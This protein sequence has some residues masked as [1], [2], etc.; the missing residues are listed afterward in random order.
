[1]RKKTKHIR[2]RILELLTLAGSP[3]NVSAALQKEFQLSVPQITRYLKGL[4]K[5]ALISSS[6]YGK[7]KKYELINKDSRTFLHSLKISHADLAKK[8]EDK[9]YDQDIAPHLSECNEAA[10][11]CIRHAST[12]LINNVID[13]SKA[14]SMSLKV[15]RQENL[16][17]IELTDDGIGVFSS[18]KKFF[19]LDNFYEAISELNKGKRTTDAKHHAGEGIYFSQRMVHQFSIEANGLKYQYYSEKKDWTINESIVKKGT[20]VTFAVDQRAKLFPQQ[21]FEEYTDKNFKFVKSDSFLV[22]PYFISVGESVVS[23]SEA[24]KLLAGAEKFKVVVLDFQGTQMIG[25]GFAD[26]AF[27]VFVNLHPNIE[28]TYKN[29][30]DSVE[31]MIGHVLKS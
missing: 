16:L 25:Q 3:T 2:S 11:S 1:M 10:K 20:H 12:E 29:A 9:I 19:K 24:K 31:K 7:G 4:E 23:R 17:F 18:I 21:V 5:D 30:N 28:I 13:H 15:R 26:E 8:G 27:R 6:G 14:K 22:E